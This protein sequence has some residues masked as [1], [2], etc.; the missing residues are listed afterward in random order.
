M[1]P[2]IPPPPVPA[3]K[4]DIR[5]V[6]TSVTKPHTPPPPVP[7][8]RQSATGLKPQG[9]PPPVPLT[10]PG[11]APPPLPNTNPRIENTNQSAQR[12]SGQPVAPPR[13]KKPTAAPPRP[14]PPK[15]PTKHAPKASME[16]DDDIDDIDDDFR[17]VDV[18]MNVVK[19]LLQSYNAQDGL[20]GPGSNLLQ[21]MGVCV[22][23]PKT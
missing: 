3:N 21:G 18:D 12:T 23:N 19:N 8:P 22:S 13:R 16:E 4:P 2:Q 20:A 9:P 1:K 14:P 17:P 6:Q 11:G 10:K 15:P 7:S 5:P